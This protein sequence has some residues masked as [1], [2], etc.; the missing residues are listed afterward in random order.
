MCHQLRFNWGSNVKV[1]V[2]AN[3]TS[4]L[5]H[6]HDWFLVA[7]IL[8]PKA[9]GARPL[10]SVCVRRL[11]LRLRVRR[12]RTRLRLSLIRR[13]QLHLRVRL[14]RRMH[15]RRL[16]L[17]RPHRLQEG[18]RL[19]LCRGLVHRRQRSSGGSVPRRAAER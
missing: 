16:L 7:S 11:R 5:Q 9:E 2:E 3:A 17:V 10:E 6:Q 14:I 12:L 19:R 1:S 8:V 4:R 18:L 13:L 15:L